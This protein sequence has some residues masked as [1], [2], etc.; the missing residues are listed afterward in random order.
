MLML[1]QRYNPDIMWISDDVLTIN[2]KW[3]HEFIREVKARNAQHPMSAS[4]ASIWWITT[5]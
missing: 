2:K 4:H 5:Y 1:K 3:T